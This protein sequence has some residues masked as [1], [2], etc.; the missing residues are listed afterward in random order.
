LPA[1][2]A[3]L[4]LFWL[5]GDAERLSA[6]AE[7]QAAGSTG[8][9]TVERQPIEQVAEWKFDTLELRDGTFLTGLIRA[10][11]E[12]EIE[13]AEI[14]RPPG[15]PM[16]VVIRP[17]DRERVTD[18]TRLA[19]DDRRVLQQRFAHFRNRARIEAGQMSNVSLS[20]SDHSGQSRWAYRGEWFQLESTA[21][22]AMTRRAV[23][24]IEQIFR[25]YRLLL[26]P[27]GRPSTDLRVLLFGSMEEYRA[28]LRGRDL[29]FASPAFYSTT[30]NLVVA[31]SRLDSYARRL[32][33]VRQQNQET[34]RQYT[35]LKETFTQ[36]L[37]GVIERLRQQGYAQDEIED[38]VKLRTAVW[39]REYEQ[40]M[41][42]LDLVEAQNDA[43]FA[44]VTREMFTR[45]Y[46]EA[47]HAYVQNYVYPEPDA[48]LP[49]WLNE[50]LAQI[51]ESGQFEA[52]TL[53]I[54]APDPIRLSR[55]QVE[56]AG[57]KPLLLADVL[58]A[59]EQDFLAGHAGRSGDRCYLYSWGL[60]YYL[61]FEKNLFRLDALEPYALN[62]PPLGPI[63]RFT[64][65]VGMPLSKFES[66][67][68]A[69]ML[70]L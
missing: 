45:L 20:R 47:F 3:F 49:R 37:G 36:R 32:Q 58:T 6:A 13:F 59:D 54:D 46:H 25:A 66:Q 17:I 22:E 51:F 40:V 30:E 23:I 1:L 52:D 29:E 70:A 69:A 53:R 38:E 7:D 60:A 41:A 16:F 15:K 64:R 26:P 24:R 50:G 14:R 4:L 44:E 57:P 19:P 31:G 8:P 2:A 9:P 63:A 21:D 10:E 61:T 55:L 65:L 42:R 28:F 62:E 67:W 33:Q 18:I 48:H 43:Q 68:R 11:N 27:R 5:L 39:Q 56:L 34:R 35:H 12:A